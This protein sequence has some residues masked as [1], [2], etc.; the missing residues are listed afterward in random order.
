VRRSSQEKWKGPIVETKQLVLPW[1][2]SS[3]VGHMSLDLNFSKLREEFIKGGMNKIRVRYMGDNLVLLTLKEGER[4][5]DLIKLN[6]DW[7]ESFFEVVD[8]WSDSYVAVHKIVWVRCYGL[9]ISLWN[10]DCFSKFVGQMASLMAI[11]E[12]TELWGNLEYARIQV[13]ILKSYSAR[14]S[15][16]VRINGQVYNIFIEEEFSTQEGSVCMCTYNHYATSENISSSESYVAKTIFSNSGNGN[17]HDGGTPRQLEVHYGG[18][19][20][21]YAKT[22]RV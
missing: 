12:A 13:R 18:G 3:M 5:A 9:P 7:F 4:M 16:G 10:K 11:D 17:R 2:E 21:C 8:P 15:K 22:T 20:N 6:K 19:K 1:M 14:L